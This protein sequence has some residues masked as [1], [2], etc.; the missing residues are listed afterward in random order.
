[1]IFIES[2]FVCITISVACVTN[3]NLYSQDAHIQTVMYGA[4]SFR[5]LHENSPF[6]NDMDIYEWIL[7]LKHLG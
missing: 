5:L 7:V 1:M 6:E 2:F 4:V 3:G